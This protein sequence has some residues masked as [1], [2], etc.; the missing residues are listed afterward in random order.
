[1]AA[2]T[3]SVAIGSDWIEVSAPLGM[4]DGASWVVEVQ[5]DAGRGL[6]FVHAVDTDDNNAPADGVRGHAYY[7]RTAAGEATVR[8]FEKKAGQFWWMRSVTGEAMHLVGTPK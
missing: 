1:M 4:A 6:G 3:K 7:P 8:V 5:D 2:L